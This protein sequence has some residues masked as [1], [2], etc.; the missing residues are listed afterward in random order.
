[1]TSPMSA[2]SSMVCS[3]SP[4]PA[5]GV[6]SISASHHAARVSSPNW[7]CSRRNP[8]RLSPPLPKTAQPLDSRTVAVN[9]IQTFADFSS[10]FTIQLLQLGQGF[11]PAPAAV[12]PAVEPR[13]HS[14]H[15]RRA[16]G[17]PDLRRYG[18]GHGG[19]K[20]PQRSEEHTSELQSLRRISYAV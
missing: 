18:G 4:G 2:T 20:G 14:S 15:Q 1:M 9:A 19:E 10:L 13:R 6:C 11:G 8:G 16:Y 3:V 12:P 5:L 17:C 7:G